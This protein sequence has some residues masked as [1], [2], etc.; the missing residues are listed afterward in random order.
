MIT[1]EQINR[2]IR[3][4]INLI[5]GEAEHAL[6]GQ[7]DDALQLLRPFATVTLLNEAR[8]FIPSTSHVT[9]NGRLDS[10]VQS[11]QTITYTVQFFKDRAYDRARAVQVGVERDDVTSLLRGLG[12]GLRFTSD[13]TNISEPVEPGWEE[14]ATLDI[15]L[16]YI[17]RTN[18]TEDTENG[19]NTIDSY[20]INATINEEEVTLTCG[21]HEQ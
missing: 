15:E 17:S 7:Q 13:I 8:E 14:R 4:S 16:A 6:R 20:K 3:H 11:A 1:E 2:A 12:L 9:T 10:I 21:E 18:L 19:A 5:V